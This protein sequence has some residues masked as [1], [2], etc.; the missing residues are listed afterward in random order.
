MYMCICWCVTEI[1]VPRNSLYSFICLGN[2]DVTAFLRH[3]ALSL[4]YCILK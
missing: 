1:K 4:F 3:G 2:Q